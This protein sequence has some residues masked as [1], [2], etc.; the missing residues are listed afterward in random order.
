M[1]PENSSLK[2]T[3][4]TTSKKPLLLRGLLLLFIALGLIFLSVA[5]L[6]SENSSFKVPSFLDFGRDSESFSVP[7]GWVFSVTPTG[8]TYR[9][10][11]ELGTKYISSRDWSPTLAVFNNSYSC[12]PVGDES[13]L[14]IWTVER[15][16]NNRPYCISTYSEGA[17]G[18][19]YKNYSYYFPLENQIAAISFFLGFPQCPNY[20][21]PEKSACER[22][23]A[24]FDLDS[25]VDQIAQTITPSQ[26]S[27]KDSLAACLLASDWGSHDYCLELL[28][29][30]RNYDDCVAAG[31]KIDEN[32]SNLCLTPDNRSFRNEANSTWSI[33][34]EA[35][36]NCEVDAAFQSH[37]KFVEL[38]L[39][40][41]SQLSAYEPEIDDIFDAVDAVA[42]KCGQIRMATE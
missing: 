32:D 27:V 7:E 6:V 34:L 8:E 12:N 5:V 9:Y 40:N 29:D 31:L 19:I 16:I 14:G 23:Q 2:T 20:D 24:A 36:N 15:T 11:S 18:T 1:N 3:K 30:I 38:D 28:A 35:I 37:Q 41:G 4:A 17:A 21:E 25:L 33:L 26:T 22:E 13:S 42:G 10:P 39:K